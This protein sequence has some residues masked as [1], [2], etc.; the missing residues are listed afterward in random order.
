MNPERPVEHLGETIAAL[1]SAL[2]A[3]THELLVMLRQFD[4][5]NGW[6]TGFLSCAHWLS[7][8]TGID[9]GAA[10]EKVRVA[11][12]LP[13]L[14]RLGGALQRGEISYAKDPR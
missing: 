13:A 12:A 7:W 8:R 5:Q 1:A 6:N 3:A 9:M 11:R 4:E 10:R 14:P 2:H